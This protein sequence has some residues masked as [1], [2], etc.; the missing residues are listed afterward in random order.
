MIIYCVI[1]KQFLMN[2]LM[3]EKKII[4][5]ALKLKY[6]QMNIYKRKDI[7]WNFERHCK[8]PLSSINLELRYG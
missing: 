7:S 6:I 2:N 1:F 3:T 8:F 5:I 4:F